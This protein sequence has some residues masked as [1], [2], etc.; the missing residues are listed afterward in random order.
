MVEFDVFGMGWDGMVWGGLMGRMKMRIESER[1]RVVWCG[2]L[3][4]GR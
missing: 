3:R 4:A 1:D 2:G